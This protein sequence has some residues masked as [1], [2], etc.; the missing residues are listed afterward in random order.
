VRCGAPVALD[1]GL[2]ENCNP[3]GLRDVSATQVH[4]IAF[5]GVTV[6]I[7]ILAVVARLA[8]SGIGPFSGEIAAITADGDA[9]AVTLTITNHG[10]SAGQTTCRLTD[11]RDRSGGGAGFILSPQ[12][13]PGETRTFSKRVTGLGSSVRELWVECSAP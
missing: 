10:R 9:L 8:V 1:A 11:P 2:C 6:A 3:L 4:G 7:I 5:I 12:L 13:A